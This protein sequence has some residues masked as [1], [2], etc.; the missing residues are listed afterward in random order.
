MSYVK[1]TWQ[2]GD[3]VTSS[4]LNNME[5]GIDTAAN[6]F[7]V[8]L[9]P[10]TADYSGTMD[11]TW[12]QVNSAFETGKQIIFVIS[13]DTLTAR[14]PADA[15]IWMSGEDYPSIGARIIDITNNILIYAFIPY[16]STGEST[17]TYGTTIYPLT[18]M[19]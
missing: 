15:V 4:A 19:S 10:T 7:V 9:T 14:V 8:T 6:P 1:K 5:D 16:W 3:T 17:N 18:P 2:T 11:K 13:S 12:E